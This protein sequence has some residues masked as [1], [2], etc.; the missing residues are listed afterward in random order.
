MTYR[1]SFSRIFRQT[2]FSL[3]WLYFGNKVSCR[4]LME[5]VFSY[6]SL[7]KFHSSKH[8]DILNIVV[9]KQTKLNEWVKNQNCD[10]RNLTI[11]AEEWT[12]TFLR[13]FKFVVSLQIIRRD[14]INVELGNITFISLET[15]PSSKQTAV[16]TDKQESWHQNSQHS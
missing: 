2:L 3:S 15:N 14:W 11:K 9:I 7:T 4:I 5:K 6:L 13:L 8:S 1:V 12:L 16:Y 10:K